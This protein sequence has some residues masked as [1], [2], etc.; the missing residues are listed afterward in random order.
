LLKDF[1]IIVFFFLNVFFFFGGIISFDAFAGSDELPEYKVKAVFMYNFANFVEWP[2]DK[3]PP[4]G[5]SLTVCVLG[6]DPFGAYFNAIKGRTIRGLTVES[7]TTMSIE[8]A[9][10]C[11]CLFISDSEKSNVAKIFWKPGE[12]FNSCW[13]TG[14]S[15]F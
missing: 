12:S 11:D 13:K 10:N 9:K 14:K 6:D 4:S 2:A 5:K 1:K 8:K 3:L 7:K 15:V